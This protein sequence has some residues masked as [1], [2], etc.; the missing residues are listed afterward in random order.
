MHEEKKVQ[1]EKYK[2]L[3]EKQWEL[4]EKHEKIKKN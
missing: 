1:E 3:Q 2:G 4:Q